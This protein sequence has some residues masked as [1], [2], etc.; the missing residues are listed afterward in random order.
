MFLASQWPSETQPFIYN[1]HACFHRYQDIGITVDIRDSSFI[2]NTDA[3]LTRTTAE[4]MESQ[5]IDYLTGGA[6]LDIQE[7]L[8]TVLSRNV[9][10]SNRGRQGSAVHLDTCFTSFVWNCTFDNN[11]AT[12]QGGRLPLPPTSLFPHMHELL[13][14]L[15]MV[16]RCMVRWYHMTQIQCR[17]AMSQH[18]NS[19][20]MLESQSC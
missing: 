15:V 18:P 1:R 9:F 17:N 12:G 16:Q 2:N 7:V 4:P 10:S 20:C 14:I 3:F 6:G 11:T 19:F 5:P 13:I 8:F